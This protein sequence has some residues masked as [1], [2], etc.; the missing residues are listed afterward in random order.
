MTTHTTLNSLFT[1]I[2][3]KIRVKKGTSQQIIADNF[4]SEIESIQT[5]ITPTG[6]INISENGIVDVTN[7]AN[8]N[9]NVS[10]GSQSTGHVDAEGLS[11]I[12]WTEQDIQNF[13][14]NGV[15][16][17]EEDDDIYKLTEKEL[18]GT[19]YTGTRYA[20]KN[21]PSLYPPSGSS[22]L[23]AIPS[24]LNLA[25]GRNFRDLKYLR[26][27][28]D[29]IIANTEGSNMFYGCTNLEKILN[30]S[31][32]LNLYYVSNMFRSCSNLKEAPLFNTGN[33]T[34]FSFMFYG[35]GQLKTVPQ[36]DT[37][38]G[39][40]FTNMFNSCTR[41]YKIPL[42]DFSNAQNIGSL[43]GSTTNLTLLGGFKN[44]GQGYSTTTSPSSSNHKLQMNNAPL[45]T[46][47]SL[48]NV[49]NN[50]YD[51]ASKGVASQSLQ[52]GDINLAKLTAEEISVATDKG[53]TVS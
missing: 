50:L 21:F 33:V 32:S 23:I 5:G 38:S 30:L 16:W 2:A 3:N 6:T 28:P 48:M 53:W 44:L 9:V 47:D 46:H 1:D 27:I 52:I 43:L 34:D 14:E 18:E 4:P 12:G 19:Y 49:I 10:G 29:V 41:L 31:F 40:N 25:A 39:T 17:D 45:I 22:N 51:I 37:H 26:I 20:P 8:A 11:Q 36:Y 13:Q 15:F 7:Y 42:L 24:G 35:C